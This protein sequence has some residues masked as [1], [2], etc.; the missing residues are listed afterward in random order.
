MVL[1]QTIRECVNV[2]TKGE[3]VEGAKGRRFGFYR[4]EEERSSNRVPSPDLGRDFNY[5]GSVSA[6]VHLP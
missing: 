2:R 4:R 6:A 3:R 1:I 5:E